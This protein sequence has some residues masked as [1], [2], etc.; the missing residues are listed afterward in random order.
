MLQ[1]LATRFCD[2]PD[3]AFILDRR[4]SEA[5]VFLNTFIRFWP[6]PEDLPV[7]SLVSNVM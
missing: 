1:V 3:Q 5:D 4:S 6:E 7:V 2:R